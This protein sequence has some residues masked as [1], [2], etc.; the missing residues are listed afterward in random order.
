M[1]KNI[2]QAATTRNNT[3]T[4]LCKH[5]TKHEESVV[6][7]D[8]EVQETRAILLHGHIVSLINIYTYPEGCY[9]SS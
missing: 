6:Q 5:R 4:F 2:S 1:E 3:G 9:V 8:G 7:E